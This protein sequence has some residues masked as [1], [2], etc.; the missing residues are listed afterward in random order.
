MLWHRPRM[1]S[2]KIS[3][4]PRAPSRRDEP[5]LGKVGWCLQP[6]P[7]SKERKSYLYLWLAT[8][9]TGLYSQG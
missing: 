9:V 6:T 2:K 7:E 4:L 8:L 1:M 5:D 3:K